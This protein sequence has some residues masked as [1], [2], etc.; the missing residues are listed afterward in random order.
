[1]VRWQILPRL[2]RGSGTTPHPSPLCAPGPP[3][4]LFLP[5]ATGAPSWPAPQL[6]HGLLAIGY[7][8]PPRPISRR[9]SSLH[10]LLPALDI[11]DRAR[12]RDHRR[13]GETHFQDFHRQRSPRILCSLSLA[14]TSTS[15]GGADP[16]Q[17]E[18][19]SSSVGR[20]IETTLHTHGLH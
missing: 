1:M 20:F 11:V 6:G 9:Q 2:S 5:S 15:A 3:H 18:L 19:V 8:R 13:G 10:T 7:L 16:S 4:F 14:P 17:L 12:L